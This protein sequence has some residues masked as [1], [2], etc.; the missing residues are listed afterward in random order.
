[1][2]RLMGGDLNFNSAVISWLMVIGSCHH[3]IA[4]SHRILST[5]PFYFPNY[6]P[7][8]KSTVISTLFQ[9]PHNRESPN[10]N[11]IKNRNHS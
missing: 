10:N 5:I 3:L 8:S 11:G 7:I 9:E 2:I 4:N 6:I 1:M